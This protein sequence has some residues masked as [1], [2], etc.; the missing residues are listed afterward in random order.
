MSK[1]QT[2]ARNVN[3]L[4]DELV[5]VCRVEVGKCTQADLDDEARRIAFSASLLARRNT[6]KA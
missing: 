6:R 3:S 1:N 5:E 4:A 2:T